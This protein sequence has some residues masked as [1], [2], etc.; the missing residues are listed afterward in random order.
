[1]FD[2]WFPNLNIKIAN[3]PVIAFNIFGVNIYYY[4]L[5]I[6]IGMFVGMQIVVHEAKRTYQDVQLYNN[7]FL[8]CIIC[9][10][11]GARLYY[12]AFSW[13][14][15]KNN[16]LSVFAIREGG[17]AIYGG[18]IGAVICAIIFCRKRNFWLFADT[19]TLGLIMGQ[20]IG[21]FGNFFNREAYGNSTDSLF[22]MRYL[23]SKVN[24]MPNIIRE[25]AIIINGF[26][27][28]QVHPTFLYESCWNLCLFILLTLYK[29]S[30]RFDGELFALY[31]FGYGLGRLWIEHLRID[32]LLFI[33]MPVSQIV[34]VVIILFSIYLIITKRMKSKRRVKI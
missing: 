19:C 33:G 27:Y 26:K 20:V 15:Y 7:Y 32:Q 3:L 1:M 5:I 30:K 28:I 21:R 22:A 25:H 12:V 8:W 24:Y 11:I 16:L 23:A 29:R 6:C 17:L 9:S 18:I 14:N 10:I 2:V 34:S 31:L 13:S 4:G